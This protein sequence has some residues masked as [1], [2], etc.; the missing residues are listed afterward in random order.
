MRV[1]NK[2]H[3]QRFRLKASQFGWLLKKRGALAMGIIY[4]KCMNS[5]LSFLCVMELFC[6]KYFSIILIYPLVQ[7][8]SNSY[9]LAEEVIM[10]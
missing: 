9:I 8:W 5:V 10:F 6:Y 7:I 3:F 2:A 4:F 1:I